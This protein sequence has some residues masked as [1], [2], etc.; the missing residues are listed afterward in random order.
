MVNNKL[1]I[2]YLK[3]NIEIESIF[4]TSAFAYKKLKSSQNAAEV[5]FRLASY[6]LLFEGKSRQFLDTMK[7]I[8]DEVESLPTL[9]KLTCL[10]KINKLYEG[11][12]MHRK[13][14]FFLYIAMG[15]CFENP[16]LLNLLPFL[17]KEISSKFFVYDIYN[18]KIENPEVFK[19]IHK[20][21]TKS[22]WNK[23]AYYAVPL[24]EDKKDMKETNKK[25]ID[26]EFR[27]FVKNRLGGVERYMLNS[28]WEPIQYNLYLNLYNYYKL[29][30]DL[31]M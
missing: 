25:R 23:N 19:D 16:D 27:L 22:Y 24:S 30:N 8:Y 9:Y 29:S 2:K 17:F 11:M 6:Y 13:S 18:E 5:N 3:F 14:L 31:K 15:L 1:C 7:R 10:F 12:K 28:I 26:K 21:L 20:R 4:E